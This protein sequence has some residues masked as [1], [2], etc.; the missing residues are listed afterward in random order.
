MNHVTHM[1]SYLKLR[2]GKKPQ[3]K[4]KHLRELRK[5]SA[6]FILHT[7]S[8]IQLEMSVRGG[9]KKE[10]TKDETQLAVGLENSLHIFD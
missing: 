9:N 6:V 8:V 4:E 3:D 10:V 1:L 2:D 5:N 7:F